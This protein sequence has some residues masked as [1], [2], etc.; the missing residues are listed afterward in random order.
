MTH[1]PFPHIWWI[2]ILQTM[3]RNLLLKNTEDFFV[4]VFDSVVFFFIEFSVVWDFFPSFYVAFCIFIFFL[5]FSITF[6]Y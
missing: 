4:C 3:E 1:N 6:T 5:F 2:S